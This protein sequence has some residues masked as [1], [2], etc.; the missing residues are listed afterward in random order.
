MATATA[1]KALYAVPTADRFLEPDWRPEGWPG[2]KPLIFNH[3]PKSIQDAWPRVD[4][5]DAPDLEAIGKKLI[6]ECGEFGFLRDLDVDFRWKREGGKSGNRLKFG[7]CIKPSGLLKHYSD[8][9]FI[10]WAAADHCRLAL[11]DA[12]QIEAL[13]Y[14]ELSHP[15]EN[16][17]GGL[18]LVGHDFEGFT[19]EL[20]RY[21]PW[22]ASL[23]EM[24]KAA[25]QLHFDLDGDGEEES[26]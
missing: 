19:G 10:V 23:K 18:I 22:Q 11:F 20:E 3:A 9:H 1:P 8:L 13:V 6:A 2:D 14:H 17:K 21:G 15:G 7:A 26:E 4:F 25:T 24:V 5:I 16:D 12:R